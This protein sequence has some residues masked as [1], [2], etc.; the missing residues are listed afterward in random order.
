MECF[1]WLHRFHRYLSKLNKNDIFPEIG[2]EEGLTL[3]TYAR[4]GVFWHRVG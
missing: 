2:R 3:A 4:R 1:P